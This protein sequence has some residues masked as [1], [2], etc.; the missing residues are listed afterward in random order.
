[1]VDLDETLPGSVQSAGTTNRS[2]R[3]GKALLSTGSGE[4]VGFVGTIEPTDPANIG[5]STLRI[6]AGRPIDGMGDS[7]EAMVSTAM[8]RKNHLG[9]GS[10]FT[11]YGAVL[12][13]KAIFGSDTDSGSDTVIVPLATEQRLTHRD[14]DVA[15]AVATVDSLTH[16]SAVTG[17][18]SADFGPTAEVTSDVAQADQALAPLNSVKSLSLY[19]LFGAVGA[20]AAII[21]LITV[22]TVRE[23]KREVGILKAIGGSNGS[24]RYQFMTEALTLAVLGGAAG[25]LAGALAASSITSSLVSNSGSSSSSSPASSSAVKNRLL[26]HLSQVHA[27]AT[28]PDILVGVGGVL[29]IAAFGSAAAS[30][31]I[32]RIQPAEVL[33]SE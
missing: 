1:V 3:A 10:T 16:L 21:F 28:A 17:E 27:T 24:I 9:I 29:L 2:A 18:I 25:L 32:S 8:A 7:D 26:E 6:V 12:T 11:A 14:H 20:S 4:P 5:A 22:M 33:R 23:R 13:V 19:S 30:Y 15:S 31:L